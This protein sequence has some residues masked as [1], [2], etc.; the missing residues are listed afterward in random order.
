LG[1]LGAYQTFTQVGP[2]Y[3]ATPGG[4]SYSG[5]NSFIESGAGFLVRSSGPAGTLTFTENSKIDGSNLVTRAAG[6]ATYLRTNLYQVSNGNAILYD[7]VLNQYDANFENRIDD[8]DA[9]KLGNFGENLGIIA[10]GQTL[11]VESRAGI[12]GY[13]TIKYRIGQLRTQNYQ[14][15][16]L[17]ENIDQYGVVAFLEDAFLQTRTRVSTTDTTRVNF[18]VIND[19]ASY[20]ANRFRLVF[21]ALAP[22]PVSFVDVR[23][24]KQG[25]NVK[26]TWKVEQE[27]NISRYEIEKSTDGRLF[28]FAG[29]VQANGNGSIST[30]YSWL[31][32]QAVKGNNFYRVRSIGNT[33]ETK[34]SSV[35]KVNFA[36]ERPEYAVFPNP[37]KADR[38]LKLSMKNAP[39]GDYMVNMINDAG[40]TLMNKRLNHPGGDNVFTITLNKQMAHGTYLLE[41]L[42]I[43]NRKTTFKVIY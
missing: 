6:P 1:T 34:L 32:A 42:D 11:I 41:L 18:S 40:Q 10:E 31:D 15:E 21:R 30:T 17:P 23:A 2:S 20:A 7:G 3:V 33:G 25:Q 4:G 16:F 8:L 35:V 13:D 39:A 36:E 27:L 9:L 14:F 37:V 24:D 28:N 5:S 29:S 22:L 43:N 38:V 26:V 12:A 19:A